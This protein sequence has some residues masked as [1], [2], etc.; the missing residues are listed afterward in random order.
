MTKK[1][2]DVELLSLY[3]MSLMSNMQLICQLLF[4]QRK[5]VDLAKRHDEVEAELRVTECM[6]KCEG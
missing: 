6:K 3:E 1:V 2:K 5:F 4:L